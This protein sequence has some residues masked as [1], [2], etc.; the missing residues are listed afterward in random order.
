MGLTAVE[1]GERGD[2][3]C[4]EEFESARN[5]SVS[6]QGLSASRFSCR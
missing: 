2:L 6:V 4:A 5:E 1:I 3:G